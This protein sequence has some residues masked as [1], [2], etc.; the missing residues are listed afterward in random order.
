MQKSIKIGNHIISKDS[1]TYIVAEMSANHNMDYE[2]AL[3]II[4]AAA[5]AGPKRNPHI[6]TGTSLKSI[7]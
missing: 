1:P 2:R 4:D 7:L 6:S 3:K 5:D